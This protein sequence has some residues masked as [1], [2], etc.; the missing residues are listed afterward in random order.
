MFLLAA[1]IA[2]GGAAEGLCEPSG[3][4]IT[5][6]VK[7]IPL[8][9]KGHLSVRLTVGGDFLTDIVGGLAELGCV[10]AGVLM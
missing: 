8:P 4:P 5:L 10:V 3:C 1:V 6:L 2:E 7:W 9:P